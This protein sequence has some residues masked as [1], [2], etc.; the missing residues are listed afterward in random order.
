MTQIGL[1]FGILLAGAVVIETVFHWPGIGTYAV[2][3]ILQSDYKAMMGFTVYRRRDRDVNLLVD[4]AQALHRPAGATMTAHGLA[5]ALRRF[6]SDRASDWASRCCSCW[7]W[8][9]SSRRSSPPFPAT[10]GT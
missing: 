7:S 9:R 5:A 10:S 1:L 6:A 2:Q 4:V 8:P 3:S